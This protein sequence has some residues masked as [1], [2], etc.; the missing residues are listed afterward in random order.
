MST[1]EWRAVSS[2]SVRPLSRFGSASTI[3]HEYVVSTTHG[4]AAF[5]VAVPITAATT[6]AALVDPR[7]ADWRNCSQTPTATSTPPNPTMIGRV[8]NEE[9]NTNPV[10]NVPNNAPAVPT[11]ERRPT[12]EPV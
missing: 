4:P 1:Y 3:A 12:T 8:G 7:A 2:Q 5:N 9:S 11:A 10:M 6:A